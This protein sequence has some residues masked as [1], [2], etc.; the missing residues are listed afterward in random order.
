MKLLLAEFLFKSQQ[1]ATISLFRFRA[2]AQLEGE[3]PL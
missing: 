2:L 3:G 1:L